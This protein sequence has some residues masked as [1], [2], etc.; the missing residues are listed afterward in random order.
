MFLLYIFFRPARPTV[1]LH[2]WDITQ[3]MSIVVYG[4]FGTACPSHLQGPFVLLACADWPLKMGQESCPETSAYNYQYKL[5]II[6]EGRKPQIHCGG[7][8]KFLMSAVLDVRKSQA[9]RNTFP[10]ILIQIISCTNEIYCGF[11]LRSL[12]NNVA[13]CTQCLANQSVCWCT[14]GLQIK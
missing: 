9:Y 14:H 11:F 2:L 5:H 3:R 6:P 4:H 1:A 13:N 8:F 12:T 10:R 7:S